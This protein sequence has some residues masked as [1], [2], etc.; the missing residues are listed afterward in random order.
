MQHSPWIVHRE[1]QSMHWQQELNLKI[2][3][4]SYVTFFF[5]AKNKI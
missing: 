5:K 1:M 4:V 3:Y 2:F